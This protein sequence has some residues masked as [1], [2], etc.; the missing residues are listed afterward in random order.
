V[1]AEKKNDLIGVFFLEGND[2]LEVFKGFMEGDFFPGI[3]VEIV[4]QEDDLPVV[5][6]VG[7]SCFP[8]VTSVDVGKDENVVVL[9]IR[10]TV[11]NGLRL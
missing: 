7:D 8:E 11:R 6:R 10:F 2:G 4:A 5:F 9:H 1:I 3:R